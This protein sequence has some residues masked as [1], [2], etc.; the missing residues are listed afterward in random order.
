MKFAPHL[1]VI[2]AIH[3]WQGV[4]AEA[5]PAVGGAKLL[6]ETKVVLRISREFIHELTGKQFKRD[7]PIEKNSFGATVKGSAHVEGTFEVKLQKSDD[8]SDFDLLV[9]GEILTQVVAS[10]RPI[11]VYAH[12]VAAFNGRRRVVFDG[13]AFTGRVSEMNV[14]YHSH[15]DQ[16]CSF[17]GGLIG[18]LT[19]G[20]ARPTVRRDLPEADCQAGNE[21][22]TELTTAIEKETDQLLV[23]MNKVG[24]LLKQGEEILRQEKVLSTSSVQHYLAATEQHLYMSIGLPGQRIPSLPRLEVSKRGPIEL[25]I[26]IKKASKEDLLTPVLKHWSF[27]K[28]FLLQRIRLRSLEL[29]KIVEQ[30]QVESVEGWYVV[31]FA[32]KLLE[33]K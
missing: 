6:P 7:E 23:T 24:P 3:L 13:N 25:W 20:I 17:R 1:I 2:S 29:G 11:Q 10:S 32:P 19:R 15:I 31:T 18:A 27:I 26:A 28:P 21:I 4:Q 5:Q 22:R 9:N 16:L 12:G 30:V 14:T 8:A 33:L